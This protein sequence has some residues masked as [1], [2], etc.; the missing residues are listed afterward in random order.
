VDIGIASLALAEA[1]I[2][3]SLDIIP[4]GAATDDD[5]GAAAA[6]AESLITIGDRMLNIRLPGKE[7]LT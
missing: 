1:F 2:R 7:C 4:R 3:K 5:K 6:V